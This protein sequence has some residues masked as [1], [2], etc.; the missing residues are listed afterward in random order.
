[1]RETKIVVVEDDAM[2]R[3]WVRAALEP[4][5]FALAGVASSAEEGRDLIRRRRPQ[6]VLLDYRLP[7]RLG[8]D[9]VRD[10]RLEGEGVPVVVMSANPEPGLNEAARGAGAQGSSLKS[11]R[12]DE[13]LDT[14]RRVRDGGTAFDTRHPRRR[15]GAALSPREREVLTLVARGATNREVAEQLA[16]GEQ[17]VKTLLARTFA[18]LGVSRRSEAVAAAYKAGLL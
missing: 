1:M 8:T 6:L 13:L 12:I 14:L 17:T 15:A 5:E 11:G 4:S 9:L 10:L 2:V 16:I 18:K 7:D 3:E